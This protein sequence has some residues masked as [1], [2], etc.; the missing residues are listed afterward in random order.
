[1]DV[2]TLV[3]FEWLFFLLVPLLLA[4]RELIGIRRELRRDRARAAQAARGSGPQ[5]S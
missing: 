2:A 4:V 5:G 3:R 1:M